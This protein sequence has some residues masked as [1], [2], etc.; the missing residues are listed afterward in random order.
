EFLEDPNL[1][2]VLTGK[3]TDRQPP[4]ALDKIDW[5]R[6]LASAMIIPHIKGIFHR[7]LK[8]ANL[9][10]SPQKET[11]AG[12]ARSLVEI[13]DFGLAIDLDRE[14]V[15][16]TCFQDLT[17]G[18]TIAGTPNFMAPELT[19]ITLLRNLKVL[20]NEELKLAQQLAEIY[21]IG[22]VLYVMLTGE[23][24]IFAKQMINPLSFAPRIKALKAQGVSG[25]EIYKGMIKATL[26]YLH[27]LE[28]LN[29]KDKQLFKIIK[30]VLNPDPFKRF[31]NCAEL[32][33]DLA[34]YL[35]AIESMPEMILEIESSPSEVAEKIGSALATPSMKKINE[36]LVLEI[37]PVL[38]LRQGTTVASFADSDL[39][40]IIA[41]LEAVGG[42][43]ARLTGTVEEIDEE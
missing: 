31:Q 33:K 21:S 5:A 19:T 11:A 35:A 4:T 18:L 20:N 37:G 38:D 27:E 10:I 25:L 39:K 1:A 26:P 15:D 16:E 2:E 14:V 9:F 3:V 8:P 42:D 43:L 22:A 32:E 40:A 28:E 13:I 6:Q 29:I 12:W 36:T 24:P 41:D 23:A 7:D 34:A 30:K 17:Q